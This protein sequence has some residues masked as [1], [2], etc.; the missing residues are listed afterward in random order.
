MP[1]REVNNPMRTIITTTII[2][3]NIDI[4]KI[5]W[6]TFHLLIEKCNLCAVYLPIFDCRGLKQ[7]ERA[8]VTVRVQSINLSFLFLPCNIMT[9]SDH[10]AVSRKSDNGWNKARKREC[11]AG[12]TDASSVAE[13]WPVVVRQLSVQIQTQDIV[14]VFVPVCVCLC[15]CVWVCVC[16]LWHAPVQTTGVWWGNSISSATQTAWRPSISQ[17]AAIDLSCRWPGRG[18]PLVNTA[19]FNQSGACTLWPDKK[20]PGRWNKITNHLRMCECA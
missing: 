9:Q 5:N 12:K 6:E 17:F 8:C 2:N 3:S 18:R 11:R 13:I 1:G 15:V 16:M 10:A 7:D 19:R 14:W 4:R 20:A